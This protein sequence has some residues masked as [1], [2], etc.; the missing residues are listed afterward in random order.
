MSENH[1]FKNSIFRMFFSIL[2]F[3]SFIFYELQRKPEQNQDLHELKP[4]IFLRIP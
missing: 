2:C 1:L 4:L 3:Y